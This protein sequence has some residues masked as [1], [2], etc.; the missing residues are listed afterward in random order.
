M[1]SVCAETRLQ[2]Y[3]VVG[4]IFL[5]KFGMFLFFTYPEWLRHFPTLF[6]SNRSLPVLFAGSSMEESV[7]VL[8]PLLSLAS[9]PFPT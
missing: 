3:S 4:G 9:L 1:T 7:W 2:L 6:S 5:I 8:V